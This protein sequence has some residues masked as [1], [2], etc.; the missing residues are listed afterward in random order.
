M[1][2]SIPFLWDSNF[3]YTGYPEFRFPPAFSF[4]LRKSLALSLRTAMLCYA[5]LSYFSTQGHRIAG[6]PRD[7]WGK[8]LG[9]G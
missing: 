6:R 5:I 8:D 9:R 2:K 3:V 4:D 7:G 1:P